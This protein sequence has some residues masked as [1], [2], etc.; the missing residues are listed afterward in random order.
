MNAGLSAQQLIWRWPVRLAHWTLATLVIVNLFNDD[1]S[2]LHRY[3]GYAAVAVVV[4]RLLYGWFGRDG[5]ARPHWPGFRSMREHV[6]SMLRGEVTRPAGHNPLGGAMTLTLWALVLL[7]G[8]SGWVSRWDMFW[9][10]DWPHE[11]HESFVIVLQVCVLLHLGGVLISSVLER[12]N[13]VR[14][15]LTG[16]KRVDES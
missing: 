11:L 14:A 9:G 10:D 8:L 1:G 13:L 5:P 6:L 2:K 7:L 4:L 15:M 16:R 3:I 12:Q